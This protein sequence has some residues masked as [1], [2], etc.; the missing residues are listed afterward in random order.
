MPPPPPTK[1]KPASQAPKA[2]TPTIGKAKKQLLPPRVVLNAVE[3]WGKTSCGSHTNNP[4][5]LM[6]RGETGYATLLGAGL[7]PEIDTLVDDNNNSKSVDTWSEL[8]GTLDYL[9]NN[10]TGHK[11][12]V[13]DALGG[14]ERLCH[15]HVC[16]RDFNDDWGDRGFASYQK[17]FDVSVSDWLGLLV[18]LDKINAKG[19]TILL[20]SHSQIRPFKNPTGEDFDRY[21]ADLHHKTWA[22]TAKWADAVLFGTF[23]TVTDD[24][25]GRTRGI[26]GTDRIIYAQRKDAWDAKNRYGMPDE[27]DIP[28]DPTKIWSTIRNQ[29]ARKE[30]K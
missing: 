23:I 11:S 2:F 9:I 25:K 19:M 16:S 13:L 15:E 5:L 26:G 22:P 7:V 17:G 4:F 12:L 24:M 20:L 6:A 30:G 27:F 10:D 18:R 14:F 3:G 8:L 28:N 1:T 29:I 21:V